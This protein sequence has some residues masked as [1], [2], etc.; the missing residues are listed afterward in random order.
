[1]E[2]LKCFSPNL[3]KEGIHHT[4]LLP[5][6]FTIQYF[7]DHCLIIA[8]SWIYRLHMQ[9]WY[10]N[11][12]A[13]YNN[14]VSTMHLLDCVWYFTKCLIKRM[15]KNLVISCIF[16]RQKH[17]CLWDTC[18][19]CTKGNLDYTF[20]HMLY[21]LYNC[22]HNYSMT[23]LYLFLTVLLEYFAIVLEYFEDLKSFRQLKHVYLFYSYFSCNVGVPH[24][25]K[26]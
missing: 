3:F 20:T 13:S 6:F 2:S 22:R 10:S 23:R 8:V 18:I 16:L 7:Q 25:T 21:Y 19:R 1:L 11:A 9:K 26:L 12:T 14:C 15:F 24:M 17:H 5:K 4:F